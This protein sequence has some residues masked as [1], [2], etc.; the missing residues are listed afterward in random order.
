MRLGEPQWLMALWAAPAAAA[1]LA[2]A[3]SRRRVMLRRLAAPAVWGV[4]A[5]AAGRGR[6]VV[7]AALAVTALAA[8]AIALARP[9]WDPRPLTVKT[10]GRDVAFVVDVSR[11]MTATD[12]APTRLERTKLWI[13]DLAGS[14]AGDRVALVA[15]A[16]GSVVKCPL[17]TDYEFFRMSVDDLS[18]QTVARGGTLIGDAI[19]KTLDSVFAE[20]EARFRDIILVTDGEDH[21]SFPVQ[22]AEQAGRRGVRIIA[23]GVGSD[24]GAVV[25]GVRHEDAAVVSKMDARSLAGVAHASAGGVFLNV[26]TGNIDLDEVYRDLVASAEKNETGKAESVVYREGF[27]IALALAAAALLLEA[28]I[29]ER[30]KR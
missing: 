5:R 10:S 26:G 15:F 17:T 27:Q 11:S 30:G 13:K 14:L 24:I 16:G 28:W 9:Q 29:H 3:W 20:E 4:V 8:T 23:L 7:K 19:R 12:L 22:A 6:V 1:L 18:P 21:E 25:P 2:W